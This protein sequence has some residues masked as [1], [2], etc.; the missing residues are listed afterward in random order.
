MNMTRAHAFALG[1]VLAASTGAVA[2]TPTPVPA[3]RITSVTLAATTPTTF[4]GVCSPFIVGLRGTYKT[5]TNQKHSKRS[6]FIWS[7]W[8]VNPSEAETQSGD[9]KETTV[10]GRRAF[11]KSFEGWVKLQADAWTTG[12]PRES[13]QLAVKITCES[14]ASKQ[15]QQLP[16][17][18]A[19]IP[20][21]N[22]GTPIN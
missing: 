12:R 2:Q 7:D 5:D 10:I 21:P 13:S 15:L 22:R 6:Q 8:T 9:G 16:T 4:R 11:E 1:T 20:T 14:L 3:G 18:P 19:Q 17:G